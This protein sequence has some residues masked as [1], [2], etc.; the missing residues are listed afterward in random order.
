MFSNTYEGEYADNHLLHL[1]RN[2]TTTPFNSKTP[3]RSEHLFKLNS[4]FNMSTYASQ[5]I[6]SS[7]LNNGKSLGYSFSV[8]SLRPE[9]AKITITKA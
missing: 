4:A 9:Y 1:I 7:L 6:N 8:D 2:K 5:F 3:L